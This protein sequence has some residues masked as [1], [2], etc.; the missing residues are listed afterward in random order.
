[1]T[2]FR[3]R[4]I[5]WRPRSDEWR[6]R[7]SIYPK[8]PAARLCPEVNLRAANLLLRAEQERE[9]RRAAEAGLLDGGREQDFYGFTRLFYARSLL[10]E[11]E[12]DLCRRRAKN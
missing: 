7:L 11:A 4:R 12:F 9:L 1:M 5:A 8:I 10:S 3:F 6:G 2:Q